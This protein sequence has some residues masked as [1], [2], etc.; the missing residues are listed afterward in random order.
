MS[1]QVSVLPDVEGNFLVIDYGRPLGM[2]TY[3]RPVRIVSPELITLNIPITARGGQGVREAKGDI[4]S[5]IKNALKEL[6]EINVERGIAED[7]NKILEDGYENSPPIK[8]HPDER[9]R[10]NTILGGNNAVFQIIRINGN[11][12]GNTFGNERVFKTAPPEIY[13]DDTTYFEPDRKSLLFM[14]VKKQEQEATCAYQYIHQT[15]GKKNGFKKLTRNYET[16]KHFCRLEPP[17]YQTW[18]RHYERERNIEVLDLNIQ[19]GVDIEVKSFETELFQVNITNV[20][21]NENWTDEEKD[22]SMNVLD[23]IRWCM[24]AKVN[25]YV[26]DFN[27]HYYMSYNH[28]QIASCHPDIKIPT[29]RHSIVVKI[30]DNHA[31]FVQDPDLKKSTCM[32]YETWKCQD[33]KDITEFSS[34]KDSEEFRSDI[35]QD[36]FNTSEYWIHPYHAIK[37]DCKGSVLDT[38]CNYGI[39]PDEVGWDKAYEELANAEPKHYRDNPPPT[40]KELLD[41]SGKTFYLGTDK[42]NGI[43]SYLYH[44]YDTLPTDFEKSKMSGSSGHK[45]ERVSYGNNRLM[46]KSTLPLYSDDLPH[47]ETIDD[48]KKLFPSLEWN[49][50]PT[51]KTIA[52]EIFKNLDFE[53]SYWSMFN[54]NTRRAFFDGEIKADNNVYKNEINKG[55]WSVDISKAYTTALSQYDLEW[56]VYDGLCEF[57]RYKG[58]FNPN[59][60][61]LVQEIGEGFPLRNQKDGLVLY[62]GCLLRHLLGKGLVIIKK[63]I[64]PIRRLHSKYFVPFVD[65]CKNVQRKSDD[66]ITFKRLINTWVG[67]LKKPEK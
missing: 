18:L 2:R 65:E 53:L 23:L 39:D 31:Y 34:V 67:G 10:L 50:L 36:D 56:N 12:V 5:G 21:E 46:A 17:Q 63:V 49:R 52:D 37:Q 57:Q 32:R 27:G 61:Y 15:F 48:L 8:I 25:C 59:L 51:I 13:Y 16:I 19:K 62:H 24:W 22:K 35:I 9:N 54:S 3:R 30:R 47:K 40:P 33:F 55:A 14:D 38:F 29:M 20:G 60:F 41:D 66:T 45:I 4:S 11:S 6:I 1:S 28:K 7:I 58:N 44:N 43:V 64:Y 26:I 42:L